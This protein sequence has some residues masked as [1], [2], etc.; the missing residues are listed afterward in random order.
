[1]SQL[2]ASGGQSTGVSASAS[3]L[4]MNIPLGL[5]GLICLQAIVK[6]LNSLPQHHNLKASLLQ[7]SAFFMA[8][9][10]HPYMTTGKTI[11]LA[12]WTFVGNVMS[13]ILNI[14]SI[15]HS[16]YFKKQVS[17][18]FMVAVTFGSDFGAKESQ[19]CQFPL[20]PHLFAMK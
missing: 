4:P 1:M 18:N 8:Q 11:A 5:I 20:F 19:T 10:S 7:H 3:V 6:T 2:F 17:F 14:L 15:C 12:I 13:L 16:F 9:L